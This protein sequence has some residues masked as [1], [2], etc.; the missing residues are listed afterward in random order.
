MPE[1]HVIPEAISHGYLRKFLE[2][3]CEIASG[4]ISGNVL[5]LLSFEKM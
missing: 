5:Y 2:F 3:L 1:I 4:V